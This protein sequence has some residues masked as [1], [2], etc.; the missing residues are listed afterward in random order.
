MGFLDN[1]G[2][3]LNDIKNNIPGNQKQETQIPAGPRL[4]QND[5]KEYN[6]KNNIPDYSENNIYADYSDVKPNQVPT[7]SGGNSLEQAL[8]ALAD[9]SK[10]GNQNQSQQSVEPVQ[11]PQPVNN[12]WM[13]SSQGYGQSGPQTTTIKTQTTQEDADPK[14]AFSQVLKGL[15]G[16]MGS[17]LNII[18]SALSPEIAEAAEADAANNTDDNQQTTTVDPTSVNKET[19]EAD[20]LESQLEAN[21]TN[22]NASQN[23]SSTPQNNNKSEADAL[24]DFVHFFNG[25]DSNDR[26]DEVMKFRDLMNFLAGHNNS[27]D[28][29]TDATLNDIYAANENLN[30]DGSADALS[31]T[32]ASTVASDEEA[33]QRYDQALDAIEAEGADSFISKFKSGID[34]GKIKS[35]DGHVI[36]LEDFDNENLSGDARYAN[37]FIDTAID[38]YYGLV[39]NP[40]YIYYYDATLYD[41][42]IDIAT[43]DG[44]EKAMSITPEEFKTLYKQSDEYQRTVEDSFNSSGMSGLGSDQDTTDA[45][46]AALN[47]ANMLGIQTDDSTGVTTIDLGDIPSDLIQNDYAAYYGTDAATTDNL[48]KLLYGQLRSAA[49]N[50]ENKYLK[51]NDDKYSRAGAAPKKFTGS[52][53]EIKMDNEG[54]F[55]TGETLFPT[56]QSSDGEGNDYKTTQETGHA[57]EAT[58]KSLINYADLNNYHVTRSGQIQALADVMPDDSN[59]YWKYLEEDE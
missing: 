56:L 38:D 52:Q 5:Q 3:I 37:F 35:A 25:N 16:G 48:V 50:S 57:G 54:N 4:N 15:M 41:M 12:Q 44:L 17:G 31:P 59:V 27:N 20:K 32:T 53:K 6:K 21:Q 7:T 49:Y 33:A 46:L 23:T 13:S 51:S 1:L 11:M 29:F 43:K 39:T 10:N 19:T 26:P 55:Y 47:E 2:K 58:R 40:E 8:R 36:K 28:S 42:G 18:E 9:K 24:V 45:V 30:T 34:N 14:S 22:S